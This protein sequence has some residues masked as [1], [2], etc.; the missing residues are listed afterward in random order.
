MNLTKPN[1][2][3]DHQYYNFACAIACCMA[4]SDKFIFNYAGINQAVSSV[5][6]H[7]RLE[8]VENN[9]KNLVSFSPP[10]KIKPIFILSFNI[11]MVVISLTINLNFQEKSSV[12]K[13]LL[14]FCQKL[15]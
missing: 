12:L 6:W 15:S 3:G 7:S 9:L 2:A 11:V 10:F 5:K 8:K 14:K 4:I 1:L 13:K